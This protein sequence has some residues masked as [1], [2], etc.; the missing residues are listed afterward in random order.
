[1]ATTLTKDLLQNCGNL[2]DM[3]VSTVGIPSA[4]LGIVKMTLP[5]I[6]WKNMAY[7]IISAARDWSDIRNLQSQKIMEN[8]KLLGRAG[9]IVLLGGSLFISVLTILQKILI[10]M[11]INDTNSTAIYA[12]L[13]AGC[14]TSD[15]SINVYLIYIGQSIQLAIMQWCVSGNDA[16]YY[17]IL[18][19][20]SGQFDILKMNFQNLPASNTEKPSIIHDFVKR[21]NHLLKI[22]HH[23]EET[24]SFVIMCH[25]LTDLCFISGACKRI[26]FKYQVLP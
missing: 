16:C 21:H 14:W 6:Y 13:G 18:T 24:F 15:L 10:N 8:N 12:A 26:F 3:L 20:L 23:L 2:N 4:L 22:C 25:L 19:H 17:H 5:R 7:M 1:M 9:F 11:K